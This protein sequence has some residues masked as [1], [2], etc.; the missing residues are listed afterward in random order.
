MP[1]RLLIIQ[2]AFIGDV[3]LATALIEK[4]RQYYTQNELEIDFLLR[5]GNENLLEAHPHIRRLWIWDKRN[6]KYRNMLQ[7]IGELR[8]QRYTYAVNVQRFA[9]SG[10]FTVLCG[11]KETAGFDKNPLSRFFT[12]RYPHVIGDGRHETERNQQLISHLTDL[13]PARPRLYPLPEHYRRAAE[14]AEKP[15]VCVAPASVWFTKQFPAEKWTELI[16]RLPADLNVLLIGGRED[17]ALCEQ[18]RRKTRHARVRNL[19]GRLGLLSSAALMENARMNYVNDSAPLHLASAVNAP[20]CAVFCSTVPAFGYTP[21]SDKSIIME[22][23]EKLACRPCGL[24]GYKACPRG[25]FRCAYGIDTD[26]IIRRSLCNS[27]S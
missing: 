3:I 19:A 21:L 10:L 8:R 7:L 25:H 18:I 6:G 4:L 14:S 11:A 16:D 23:S 26:E 13:L 17:A 24:H 5:K 15:Y 20:V 9:A 2:T 1:R 12:R 22:T 27:K